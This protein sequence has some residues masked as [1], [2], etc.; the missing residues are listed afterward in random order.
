MNYYR[1]PQ[2]LL[3]DP[4]PADYVTVAPAVLDAIVK[5]WADRLEDLVDAATT[6]RTIRRTWCRAVA[7]ANRRALAT[8]VRHRVRR[9]RAG[10]WVVEP[11]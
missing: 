7:E 4:Q 9:G 8:G 3:L 5:R 10:Y 2:V 11:K 1:N 6:P